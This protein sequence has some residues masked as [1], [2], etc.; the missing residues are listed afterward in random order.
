METDAQKFLVFERILDGDTYTAIA[1]DLNLSITRISQLF[2]A[3]ARCLW[4]EA[5]RGFLH[6][7]DI[8]PAQCREDGEWWKTRL[9]WRRAFSPAAEKPRFVEAKELLAEAEELKRE[10]AA[11]E[12]LAARDVFFSAIDGQQL[13]VIAA[14]LGTSVH[15]VKRLLKA[16]LMEL[17]G[18]AP[19]EAIAT[20]RLKNERTSL[21]SLAQERDWAREGERPTLTKE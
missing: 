10:I 20:F 21:L 12:L 14:H 9:A 3:A 1:V 2:R 16:A 15:N 17:T 7:K 11:L 18:V 19:G 8:S 5:G 4:Q 13:T 6:S